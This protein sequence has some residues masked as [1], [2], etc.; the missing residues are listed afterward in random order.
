MLLTKSF[1]FSLHARF[2]PRKSTSVRKLELTI[3]MTL[4]SGYANTSAFGP[5][6][7]GKQKASEADRV[8]VII[9]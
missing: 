5:V 8:P 1:H 2:Y 4:I 7:E 9:R 6:A 3:S